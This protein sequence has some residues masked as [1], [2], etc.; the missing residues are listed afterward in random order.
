MHNKVA[1][2]IGN[3]YDIILTAI[4][5][6]IQMI[7]WSSNMKSNLQRCVIMEVPNNDEQSAIGNSPLYL[8]VARWLHVLITLDC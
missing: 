5:Q 4:Y 8:L 7:Y 1:V 3:P 6:N 2:Y